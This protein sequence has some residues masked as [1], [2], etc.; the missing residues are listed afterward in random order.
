M[1]E[2]GA[3]SR[4]DERAA[5]WQGMVPAGKVTAMPITDK[6]SHSWQEQDIGINR[7]KHGHHTSLGKG[8]I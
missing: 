7:N 2:G 3:G 4:D 5:P 8:I 1:R 6:H